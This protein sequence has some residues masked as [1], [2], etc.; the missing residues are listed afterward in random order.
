[1]SDRLTPQEQRHAQALHH[2]TSALELGDLETVA[3][4]LQEA[5]QDSMLEQT[6]LKANITYQK[7]KHITLRS[8][9]VKQAHT[10]L[11]NAFS[12]LEDEH[13][14]IDKDRKQPMRIQHTLLQQEKPSPVYPSTRTRLHRF[15]ALAQTLAAVLVVGLV[16][17]GFALLFASRHQATTTSSGLSGTSGHMTLSHS[18]IVASSD[19]G[20]V[21]GMRPDTGAVA[22]HYATG[23]SVFGGDSNSALAVQGQVVYYA[24]NGQLYALRATNGTLLWHKD[25]TLSGSTDAQN[26]YTKIIVEQGIV[27]VSGRMNGIGLPGGGMYALRERDGVVLWHYWCDTNSLLAVHNGVVYVQK[28]VNTENLQAL[29]ASD[30]SVLWS[31]KTPVIAVVADD[32]AVYVYSAHPREDMGRNKQSKFVLALSMRGTLL[33]SRPVVDDGVNSLLMAQGVLIVGEVDGKTY[34]VCAYRTTQGSQAWC[35]PNET[36]PLAVNSTSYVVLGSNVYSSYPVPSSGND[37]I[38]IDAHN[39]RDGSLRWSTRFIENFALGKSVAMNKTVYVLGYHH[40]Y[41]LADSNGR[42]RWQLLNNANAF[43]SIAVGSW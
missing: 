22:W 10:V 26:S 14:H 5:E 41:A 43:S 6:L 4:I 27:F 13:I 11:L 32:T 36:A 30:G 23:K 15:S 40:V 34:H 37:T 33:W 19:D 20:T 17:S 1:M 3:T 28:A 38:R 16:V 21:Y 39:V 42:I 7:D 8:H 18:A 24:D 31:Y 2:Y 9:E 25:L 29:R 12:S 35:T